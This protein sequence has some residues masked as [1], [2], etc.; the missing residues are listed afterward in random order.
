MLAYYIILYYMICYYIILYY[1]ILYYVILCIIHGIFPLFARREGRAPRR[2][3][4]RRVRRGSPGGRLRGGASMKCLL[5]PLAAL[6]PQRK[7]AW[8]TRRRGSR[9][10]TRSPGRKGRGTCRG[11]MGQAR[12]WGSTDRQA[13]ALR[14][15]ERY[16]G[17]KRGVRGPASDCTDAYGCTQGYK[18]CQTLST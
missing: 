16:L 3:R 11:A 17:M 12:A 18:H 5:R 8:P 6:P 4:L 10:K 9:E 13:A 2:G 15:M 14:G 7:P 1:I